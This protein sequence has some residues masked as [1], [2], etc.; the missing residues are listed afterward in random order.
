M[1]TSPPTSPQQQQKLSAKA[2]LE[3]KKVK[4]YAYILAK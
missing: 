3:K 2:S 4:S 1:T